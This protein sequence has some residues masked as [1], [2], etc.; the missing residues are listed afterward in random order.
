MKHMH[1]VKGIEPAADQQ[2]D[3][4]KQ[5]KTNAGLMTTENGEGEK[6]RKCHS[7]EW[8]EDDWWEKRKKP[9][10]KIDGESEE[11][12]GDMIISIE[13]RSREVRN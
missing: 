1:H 3:M 10:L 4:L 12:N 9:T 2:I 5:M 7:R 13:K 8:A 11:E 6:T